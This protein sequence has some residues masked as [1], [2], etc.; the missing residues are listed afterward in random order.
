MDIDG[1]VDVEVK[2]VH[3]T[4]KA[5]CCKDPSAGWAVAS[6]WIPFSVINSDSL[7]ELEKG[8]EGTIQ[9]ARWFAEKEGIA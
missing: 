5:V 1:F 6:F 8:F 3:L 9:V 2:V 7:A 4:E